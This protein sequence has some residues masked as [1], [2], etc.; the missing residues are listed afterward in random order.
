MIFLTVATILSMGLM[1]GTEFSVSAFINPALWKLDE[2]PREHAVRLFAAKLGRVMPFWYVGNFL[3]LAAETILL[4]NQPSYLLLALACAVWVAVIVL[5][6]L[7][8]VPINN[9]LARPHADMR[10]NEAHRQHRRWDAM[11]RARVVALS[12][13]FVLLLLAIHS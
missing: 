7:F 6:L 13:A 1:I 8:L 4:R 9:R 3:L 2:V 5:T 12:A 10:L 11:H